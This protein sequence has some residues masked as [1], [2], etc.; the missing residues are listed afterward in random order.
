[1]D[2]DMEASVGPSGPPSNFYNTRNP[3]ILT[4]Y[5]ND[6]VAKDFEASVRPPV[7]WH[8]HYENTLFFR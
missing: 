6:E 7:T 5:F 1:M 2:M 8:P 4:L 3:S